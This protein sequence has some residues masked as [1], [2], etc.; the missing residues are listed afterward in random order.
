MASVKGE[1]KGS[2]SARCQQGGF[3]T[4]M[5]SITLLNFMQ[6]CKHEELLPA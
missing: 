6:R 4:P 5:D 2:V 3:E 1:V